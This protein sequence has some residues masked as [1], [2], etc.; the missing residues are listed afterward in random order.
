MTINEIRESDKPFLTPAEVAEAMGV[1]P[2]SIRVA[3]RKNPDLLGFPVSVI[4]TRTRIPREAFI[5]WFEGQ[6]A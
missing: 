3:A 5:G 1:D 4:G 2:Q 6:R